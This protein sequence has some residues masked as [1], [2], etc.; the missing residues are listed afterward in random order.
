MSRLSLL[1]L[2]F[3]AACGGGGGGPD[4]PDAGDVDAGADPDAGPTGTATVNATWSI[5]NDGSV[6]ACPVGATTAAILALREGDTTPYIDA[7]DCETGAGAAA[8]LPAGTYDIWIDVTDTTGATLYAESEA[9]TITLADD[10]TVSADFI[11]DAYNGFWDVS[12]TLHNAGGSATTCAAVTNDGVSILSTNSSTNDALDSI[13]N[14]TDGEAPGFVTNDPV[15]VGDYVVSVSLLN[16]AQ[17]A[18][19]AAPDIVTSIE[20]GNQF[21]DLGVLD[22]T[23]F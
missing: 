22:I 18:I 3:A 19:G 11:I 15:P 5:V 13:W 20:H 9:V 17:D 14:C 2:V 1:V 23:L 8:D 12:W 7:Y 16:A 10:A 4:V 6:A 21:V